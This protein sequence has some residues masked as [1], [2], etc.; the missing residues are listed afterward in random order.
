MAVF[1]DQYACTGGQIYNLAIGQD[2]FVADLRPLVQPLVAAR[3]TAIGHCCHPYDLCTK[4]IAE[5]A[6]VVVT[7]ASGNQICRALDTESN[8]AWTGYANRTLHDQIAP[9][10][11]ELLQK[12]GALAEIKRGGQIMQA[13]A[14]CGD[15][16]FAAAIERVRG[17]RQHHDATLRECFRSDAPI[18]MARAPGRLDVMGGIADYSGSLVLEM[19]IAEAA[20]VSVQASSEG[21][22]VIASLPEDGD[23]AA[24]IATFPPDYWSRLC[25]ADYDTVRRE[26]RETSE[27]AWA[28]Y[29][30]GPVIVLMREAGV[31][32]GHGLRI[33]VD[34]QVPEG[35]GL[36]SSAA[37]EVATLRA[38]AALCGI[39][40]AGKEIARLCQ[41]A[42]NRIAGRSVRNH[43][44]NDVGTG[45]RE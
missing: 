3:G 45:T 26:L 28:A 12:H 39:E 34:S 30:L 40:L 24:R 38:V 15:L 21:G 31:A 37:I 16:G 19:P 23:A 43:G 42:E 20:F 10:L 18:F 36:S 6:G 4:L 35:K 13:P 32:M 41:L 7:D 9:V 22:V 11:I 8:V 33:V 25:A 2:R 17:L 5:E 14:K 27:S 1:E 29:V 44:S